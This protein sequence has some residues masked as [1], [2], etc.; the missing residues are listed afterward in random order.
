MNELI[1]EFLYGD[2]YYRYNCVLM[3]YKQTVLVIEFRYQL[4]LWCGW[5]DATEEE[6][7]S[8]FWWKHIREI[9]KT[10]DFSILENIIFADENFY[11]SWIKDTLAIKY[12][13]L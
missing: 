3:E 12:K 8:F 13:K 6:Q 2:K 9:F 1:Q 4:G 10:T 7:K 5:I 11:N